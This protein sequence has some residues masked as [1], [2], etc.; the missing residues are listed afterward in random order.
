MGGLSVTGTASNLGVKETNDK[1]K[2]RK[3]FL[4]NPPPSILKEGDFWMGL[5]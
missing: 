1:I 3:D 5:E 2:V 4:L